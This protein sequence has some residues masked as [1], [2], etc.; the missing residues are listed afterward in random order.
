MQSFQQAQTQSL[1][2]SQAGACLLFPSFRRNTCPGEYERESG[3]G[4][5]RE[6]FHLAGQGLLC[7]QAPVESTDRTS[8]GAS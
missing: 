6:F 1:L 4:P 3:Q 2:E 7:E 5:R 8:A